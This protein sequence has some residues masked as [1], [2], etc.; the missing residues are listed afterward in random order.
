MECNI[1][2]WIAW[3]FF[4]M[5]FTPDPGMVI[6]RTLGGSGCVQISMET[7]PR[8]QLKIPGKAANGLLRFRSS[9]LW[10]SWERRWWNFGYKSMMGPPTITSPGS[11]RIRFFC[12]NGGFCYTPQKNGPKIKQIHGGLTWGSESQATSG[13][14]YC[15][16]LVGDSVTGPH[17]S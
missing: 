5:F 9:G 13:S 4:H 2:P 11:S 16:L 6:L 12:V 15:A 1:M 17:L 10:N 7:T 3:M 8:H 14:Y